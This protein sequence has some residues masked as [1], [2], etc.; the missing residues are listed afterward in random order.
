MVVA[1]LCCGSVEQ[2]CIV[3]NWSPVKHHNICHFAISDIF[4]FV[5][6]QAPMWDIAN[7]KNLLYNQSE[8]SPPTG[9]LRFDLKIEH[10][11][12]SSYLKELEQFGHQVALCTAPIHT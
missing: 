10:K 7:A 12:D 8:P 1:T 3:Y 9:N 5:H 4:V 2:Y 11:M 6:Y